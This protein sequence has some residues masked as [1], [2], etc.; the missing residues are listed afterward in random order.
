MFVPRTLRNLPFGYETKYLPLDNRKKAASSIR[1]RSGHYILHSSISL[2]PPI[3]ILEQITFSC[4][5]RYKTIH[6]NR[7]CNYNSQ[8]VIR[9]FNLHFHSLYVLKKAGLCK[10]DS[11]WKFHVRSP[12]LWRIWWGQRGAVI[13][14]N[15]IL[16]VCSRFSSI[17][18]IWNAKLAKCKI[19]A[20]VC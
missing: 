2:S 10:S 8:T 14:T 15:G 18:I 13:C 1:H 19:M 9:A 11:V 5:R 12:W 3:S 4:K 20:P 7:C 16:S 6:L 17:F